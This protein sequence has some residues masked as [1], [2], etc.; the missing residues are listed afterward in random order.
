MLN[1]PPYP[2]P[3]AGDKLA[4]SDWQL[5]FQQIPPGL[6]G[7]VAIYVPTVTP[8]S[9]VISAA[10]AVGRY[11]QIGKLI[12]IQITITITTNGTGAGLITV[13]L[14]FASVNIAGV[15]HVMAGRGDAVSGKM[16]QSRVR[17]NTNQLIVENYDGTYPGANGES[18]VLS[19]FYEVA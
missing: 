19:G 18:L 4:T 3:I 14:P 15:T 1:A 8:Q 13:T 6:L 2:S 12:F 17:P 11:R 10:S 9:G 7:P 5:W 16:L